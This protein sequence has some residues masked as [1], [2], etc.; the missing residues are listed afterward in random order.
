MA[1]LRPEARDDG[2]CAM[3]VVLLGLM[4]LVRP[5]TAAGAVPLWRV[6]PCAN[7]SP[8]TP[9]GRSSTCARRCA[10][11]SAQAWRSAIRQSQFGGGLEFSTWA[12]G[13][14]RRFPDRP[15]ASAGPIV[16]ATA[17]GERDAPRVPF[18]GLAEG[19]VVAALRRGLGRKN[20]VSLQQIR[21][22]VDVLRAEI[23]V[24]HALASRALYTGASTTPRATCGRYG[25]GRPSATI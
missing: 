13:Y 24:E 21:A 6:R 7:G 1:R 14:V 3:Q 11:V 20:R 25:C 22:A 15:D 5:R 18:V 23:G 2:Q 17:A 8:A 19:Q 10:P 4:L 12:Q 16:T 9:R